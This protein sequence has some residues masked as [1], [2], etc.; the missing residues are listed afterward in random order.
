[1][2]KFVRYINPKRKY[3]IIKKMQ[4][5]F[6]EE[7]LKSF[8]AFLSLKHATVY[9]ETLLVLMTITRELLLIKHLTLTLAKSISSI[10]K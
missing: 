9:L 2:L 6:G 10:S 1:M 8:D 7:L 5:F 4:K 3:Y